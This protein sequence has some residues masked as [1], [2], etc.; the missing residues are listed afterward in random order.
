MIHEII[1]SEGKPK[2]HL[3]WEPQESVEGKQTITWIGKH[4]QDLLLHY[5]VRYTHN[6]ET[7]QPIGLGTEEP[8]Q[9][10]DFD[11]LP[12]SNQCKFVIV[13]TDGVNTIEVESKSFRVPVKLC[14]AMILSPEDDATFASN[15]PVTL[16]GQG[17]YLEENRAETEALVWTSSKD[18][19]LGKGMILQVSKLSPGSHRIMLTAG[20]GERAG[21]ATIKIRIGREAKPII[22][23]VKMGE[24]GH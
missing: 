18:G 15:E 10:I 16:Q 19:E 9:E 17:F 1:V 20:T 2:V 12:G 14:Q 3:T 21:K 22:Q 5:L 8:Q 11:K 24:G 23:E 7:W 4:S 13:A 6:G